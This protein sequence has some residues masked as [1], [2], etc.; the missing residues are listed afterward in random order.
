MTSGPSPREGLKPIELS[1]TMNSA[2]LFCSGTAI[3]QYY[4]LKCIKEYRTSVYI[5][6]IM[7]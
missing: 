2:S 5:L 4:I 3:M 1:L 6:T 7:S